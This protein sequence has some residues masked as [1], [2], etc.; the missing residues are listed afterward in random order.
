MSESV[1]QQWRLPFPLLCDIDRRVIREWGILKEKEGGGIPIPAIFVIDTDRRIRFH[2]VD[3]TARRVPAAAVV[4]FLASRIESMPS[5]EIRK[6]IVPG[7]RSFGRALR[8]KAR[9]RNR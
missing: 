9:S 3:G 5:R 8:N 6:T 7:L 2:S 1:R 4:K